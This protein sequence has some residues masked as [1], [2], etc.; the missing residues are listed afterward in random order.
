MMLIRFVCPQCGFTK[1]VEVEL[2]SDGLY[3]IPSK[4]CPD[5]DCLNKLTRDILK[6][7]R[8]KPERPAVITQEQEKTGELVPDDN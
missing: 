2:D 5:P 7:D 4:Y 3:T 6:R 1:N 8:V